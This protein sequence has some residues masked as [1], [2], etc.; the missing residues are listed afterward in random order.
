[1]VIRDSSPKRDIEHTV[2]CPECDSRRLSHDGNRGELAC[3]DCGLILE[4]NELDTGGEWRSFGAEQNDEKSRVGSPMS[5]TLYDKGLST[6]I[7]WQNKDYSGRALPNAT[8]SQ[9]YRM[10]KWQQRSRIKDTNKRNLARA[11]PEIKRICV[12]LNLPRSA[13]EEASLVY[14]KALEKGL[15]RGRSIDDLVAASVHLVTNKRK[16]GRTL[17][18]ISYVSK[19][20]R[21]PLTRAYKL[22]RRELKI[23]MDI[24]RPQ[25]FVPGF[26]SKLGLPVEVENKTMEILR[27]ADDKE[28]T[29]GKTP[30]G[31]AAAAIYIA[32]N[33]MD[34]SRTQQE[35]ARISD[36]TEVTIRNRYKEL[37]SVIGI[38]LRNS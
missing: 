34:R 30:T 17:D 7:D 20:K 18:E 3:V 33:I 24:N 1:M 15:T 12:A 25:D 13:I 11:L 37:I 2:K 6:D 14:R 35:I 31:I 22:I 29:N 23:R 27:A 10:R 38:K 32:S 28:I 26:C 21:K 16:L 4:E 8:R 19:V 36:V 5:Y 9:Y